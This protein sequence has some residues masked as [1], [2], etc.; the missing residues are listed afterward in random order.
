MKIARISIA[1]ALTT[2]RTLLAQGV[3]YGYG[4]KAE[5]GA[6]PRNGHRWNTRSTGHLSTPIDTIE[7]IDCSGG[8]RYIVYKA[9]NGQLILP[10]GSQDQREQCEEWAAAGLIHKVSYRDAAKY[11]TGRRLFICFIKPGTNGCGS[12]GHVW[13]LVQGSDGH[14][15]TLESHGGGGIDSR[16]WD[17]HT[18][19]NENYSCYEL[20]TVE[21]ATPGAAKATA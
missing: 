7:N 12:V 20:P 17:T 13:L 6:D 10:D 1:L 14:A 16:P 3:P 2:F 19:I 15:V 8:V 18:L 11:M 4:A 5:G 21:G 9:T